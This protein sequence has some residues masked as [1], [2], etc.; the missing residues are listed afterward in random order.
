VTNLPVDLETQNE[1][2]ELFLHGSMVTLM[3]KSNMST[4][5]ERQIPITNEVLTNS[6]FLYNH[7]TD[8]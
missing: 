8:T 2:W 1:Y 7:S 4:L 3:Q 6:P 5:Q